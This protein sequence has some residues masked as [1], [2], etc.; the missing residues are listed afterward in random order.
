MRAEALWSLFFRQNPY[1]G[2]DPGPY[3]LDLQGWGSS[4]P[5]LAD[6]VALYRPEII[7]EVG[8]WKGASAIYIAEASQRQ[9]LDCAV[10]CVDT[11]LGNVSHFLNKDSPDHF[12][13][14]AM[15]HGYPQLYFQFL[16][17]VVRKQCEDRIDPLPQT[18]FNAAKILG[19]HGIRAQFIYIDAAHE[20]EEVLRDLDL[21]WELL[22]DGGC[23]IGDDY[24][25]T[26]PGVPRAFQEFVRKRK[27]RLYVMETKCFVAKGDGPAPSG[28]IDVSNRPRLFFDYADGR[29][30]EIAEPVP[31]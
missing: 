2:F 22:D 31:A 10:I 18:R 4:H 25:W 27:L 6:A 20:Y 21:Y 19:H 24:H 15:K 13:S 12:P 5:V 16:A 8:S 1:R 28:C 7:I 23:L 11:W 26:W 30:I 17:N 29:Y 14:L 9:G 3:P